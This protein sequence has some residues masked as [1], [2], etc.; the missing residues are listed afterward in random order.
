[1]KGSK[2]DIINIRSH[3]SPKNFQ[4]KDFSQEID[5][6][7]VEIDA[8]LEQLKSAPVNALPYRIIALIQASFFRL[9]NYRKGLDIDEYIK[10]ERVQENGGC[11]F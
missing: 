6:G 9:F 11:D 1:M 4:P 8:Q 5:K 7:I 3:T 2:H 10:N